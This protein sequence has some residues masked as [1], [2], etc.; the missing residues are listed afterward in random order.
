MRQGEFTAPDTTIDVYLD[1]IRIINNGRPDMGEYGPAF[2]PSYNTVSGVYSVRFASNA[3]DIAPWYGSLR[4]GMHTVQFY[5]NNLHTNVTPFFVD[6]TEPNAYTNPG[7]INHQVNLWA[8]LTDLESGV[9]TTSVYA[10]ISDCT[11]SAFTFRTLFE[12]DTINIQRGDSNYTRIDSFAVGIDVLI[13]DARRAYVV[14]AEAMRFAPV[15]NGYRASFTQQWEQ[16]QQW[17]IENNNAGTMCVTWAFANK[18]CNWNDSTTYVYTIDVQA[19]IVM[20][21]SPVGA[22][23]DDDGDGLVNEDPLD[24]INND[25]D[26]VWDPNSQSWRERVDED[27]VNFLP[28]TFNFGARPTIQAVINDVSMCGSGASGVDVTNMWLNIDGHIFR[29]ADTTTAGLNYRILWPNG[30]DD[31]YLTFGGTTS[32]VAADPYYTPGEHRITVAAPDSAGNVGNYGSQFSWTYYIRASGPAISFDTTG[33]CGVWFNPSA[34]NEFNFCVDATSNTPIMANGIQYSVY[35]VPSGILISG[36]TTINPATP[37]HSCVNYILSGSFPQGETGIEVRVTAMNIFYNENDP[38]NGVSHSSMTFWADNLAP[39]FTGHTPL[40][41]ASFTRDQAIVIEAF[42]SDDSPEAMKNNST[43]DGGVKSSSTARTADVRVGRKNADGSVT[44]L[45]RQSLDLSKTSTGKDSRHGS[46]LDDNG[47]GV[48]TLSAHMTIITPTG[49]VI[50]IPD[51]THQFLEIDDSHVKY[52][53]VSG[54]AAGWYTVNLNVEDCVGNNGSTMWPFQVRSAAP[55]IAYL[56]ATDGECEYDGYWNPA[57]PLHLRATVREMDG[58]N[59]SAENIRVDVLRVFSCPNGTCVDTIIA[60]AAKNFVGGDP[61]PLITNQTLR[62]EAAYNTIDHGIDASEIRIVVTATNMLGVTASSVQ[63]FLI[64]RTAPWITVVAPAANSTLPTNQTVVISA[65]FSDNPAALVLKTETG[66]TSKYGD[67]RG[68]TNVGP[69]RKGESGKGDRGRG[70]GNWAGAISGALDD[71]DGNSGIDRD[72]ITML[73][74]HHQ[75]GAV[76]TLTAH[77]AI[78]TPNNITWMGNLTAGGY[79]V[80]LSICDRVCNT[81]SINWDFTVA[82][83]GNAGV[84]YD[85]PYYVSHMP[86]VFTMH[87]FGEAIDRATMRLDI[88]ALR[89]D[90]L[91]PVMVVTNAPVQSI[92]DSVWYTANFDLDSYVQLRLT[93]HMNFTYGTAVPTGSQMYTID[94]SAPQITGVTPD[95]TV[96][97]IKGASPAMTVAFAENGPTAIDSASVRVWLENINSSETVAGQLVVTLDGARRTG[98]ARL[99]V[100]NLAVG[101]YRL[102]AHLADIAGNGVDANWNYSVIDTTTPPVRPDSLTRES[103]YNYPNPFTPADGGTQ[104]HLPIVG[105]GAGGSTVSIKIY[106]FS[107]QFV[108][109]VYEGAV[110]NAEDPNLV[111]NGTN[112]DGEMVANGVYLAHVKTTVNGQVKEDVVKVAFKNKQ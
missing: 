38:L 84:R 82:E 79:T 99:A 15:A 52:V 5:S 80:I 29:P 2:E 87:T 105:G 109:T 64:D 55:V 53:L 43:K 8:N 32:G 83:Q 107:G 49:S 22:G 48:R 39:H 34:R 60:N 110:T 93:L 95:P 100:S 72:C 36:P 4:H 88:Q 58:I 91:P 47:S 1:G 41:S 74:L 103:A 14:S 69:V 54:Q 46:S 50:T 16:L 10:V 31:A 56:P 97:L 62:I 70:L 90:T 7:Y 12:I 6:R 92:G 17:L 9:D 65:N 68:T 81:N 67:T 101:S 40:D 30:T 71:L 98:T 27:L 11:P 57:Y 44:E 73:L 18:V 33:A 25:N 45:S 28:D 106:D 63:P 86:R 51:A 37:T 94:G 20:P 108:A 102:Y 26:A 75:G 35:T 13:N 42:F 112:S 89:G 85:A 96:A 78:I 24:C 21:V 104:F 61:D 66:S 23:I 111:W 19:P 3:Y 77:G 59:V 76:D